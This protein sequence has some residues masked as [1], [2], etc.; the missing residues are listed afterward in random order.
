WR[1]V[2]LARDELAGWI[3]SF[4]RYAGKGRASAD[5]ACWLP[6]FSAEDLIVDRKTGFP[7]TVHVPQAAGCVIGNI[8]PAILKRAPGIEH[9]ESGLAAR[10]LLTWPPRMPKRWTDA[11]IDPC[12]EAELG[13][14][15]D[16]LYKL[17]PIVGEDQNPR[18]V[19]VRLSPEAKAAWVAYYNAHAAEQVD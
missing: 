4:D 13:R 18:S 1:G 16:R 15:V 19:L 6:L 7:R 9:R 3:G 14:L 8:P 17:Q 2:L 12:V 10:L 5:A 11:D